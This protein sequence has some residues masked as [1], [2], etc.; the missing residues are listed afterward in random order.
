MSRFGLQFFPASIKTFSVP[1]GRYQRVC[2]PRNTFCECR[3][4]LQGFRDAE[5]MPVDQIVAAEEQQQ[6]CIREMK[7]ELRSIRVNVVP[8]THISANICRWRRSPENKKSL[9]T[10][11]RI[12]PL[13]GQRFRAWRVI[14]ARCVCD[15]EK[16]CV[17]SIGF[18]VTAAS[19]DRFS[20]RGV[21]TG[22]I[23]PLYP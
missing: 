12:S 1:V 17:G 4:V 3:M 11:N 16:Y 9:L 23:D 20:S 19:V 15:R 18:R 22:T 7:D 13:E 14:T 2:R 10:D 5:E 6:D 8:T 21:G